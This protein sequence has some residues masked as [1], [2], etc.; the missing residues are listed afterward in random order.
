[1]SAI[2]LPT[3]LAIP[4]APRAGRLIE[5]NIMVYRRLWPVLVS[6]LAEPLLYLLSIGF[7]IGALVGSVAA[8]GK[9]VPYAIFVAPALMATSAMNGAIF[10][11]TFNLFHKLRYMRL[12]DAILA[13]PV[14]PADVAVGE[15]AW[16]LIRGTIYAIGFVIVM[17]ALR[18]VAS[19]TAVLAIPASM[20]IGF[21]FAALGT[22][23][24]TY[25]KSWQDFDRVQLVLLPLFLFSGTFFP[26]DAYPA[27]IQVL[28]QLTP[29]YHG[30]HLI[31]GLTTG[32]LDAGL[33]LDIVYLAAVGMVGVAITSRRLG[34]LL[35]K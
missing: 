23:A 20:L 30:V 16:A 15:V 22:A 21:A 7:G 27:A 24:T 10:D 32:G 13:T 33:G 29:L 2:T 14:G 6:G 35:L 4:F 19:P 25:M 8:G 17:T 34:K 28:V 5:R 31:R 12:Y 11:S 1:M 26:V 18:L 3:T 9:V